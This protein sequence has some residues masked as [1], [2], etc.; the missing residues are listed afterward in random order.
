[1]KCVET[2]IKILGKNDDIVLKYCKIFLNHNLRHT[3]FKKNSKTIIKKE[4]KIYY[5]YYTYFK[6]CV[7]FLKLQKKLQFPLHL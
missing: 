7:L 3:L 6:P 2:Y 1:M 4:K 5:L